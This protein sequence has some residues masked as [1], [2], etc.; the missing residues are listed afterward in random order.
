MANGKAKK[1]NKK[2]LKEINK[3]KD[4][5]KIYRANRSVKQVN[6]KPAYVVT[7]KFIQSLEYTFQNAAQ[8]IDEPVLAALHD[9]VMRMIGRPDLETGE[10]NL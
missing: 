1:I 8:A 2:L 5:V 4:N 7:D 6:I 3:H 10:N 9:D